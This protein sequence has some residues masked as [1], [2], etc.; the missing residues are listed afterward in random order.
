VTPEPPPPKRHPA[1]LDKHKSIVLLAARSS[2]DR[3]PVTG[4]GNRRSIAADVGGDACGRVLREVL[5]SG[6]DA[7]RAIARTRSPSARH[8]AARLPTVPH[9]PQRAADRGCLPHRGQRDPAPAPP[10]A[11][12][13]DLHPDNAVPGSD[14]DVSPGTPGRLCH[15]PLPDS[16]L[17]S[18]AASAPHGCPGPVTPAVNARAPAPAPPTRQLSR[19]PG[20][21]PQP[22]AHRLPAAPPETAGQPGRT[23]GCT[24]GSAAHVK[25]EHAASAGRPWPSVEKPTVCTDRPGAPDGVRL[26]ASPR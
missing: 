26:P 24:P 20:P 9:C 19:S 21:P 12:A 15:R 14:R 23:R 8:A 13:G 25:P 7:S 6:G 22:S 17:P 2:R 11:A 3:R 16:S 5:P 1:P 4:G 10:A 18:S